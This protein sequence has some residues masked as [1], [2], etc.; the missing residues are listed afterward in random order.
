MDLE[1][2]V[3]SNALLFVS[4]KK[5][6]NTSNP[7]SRRGSMMT[8]V[9]PS[10]K[11]MLVTDAEISKGNSFQSDEGL[12]LMSDNGEGGENQHGGEMSGRMLNVNLYNIKNRW[13]IERFEDM[14]SVKYILF[15]LWIVALV[16]GASMYQ[17]LTNDRHVAWFWFDW[18]VLAVYAI[19]LLMSFIM[20]IVATRRII[21]FF[22]QLYHWL[23][24]IGIAM[25]VLVMM[26]WPGSSAAHMIKCV[27]GMLVLVLSHL[28]Y[29]ERQAALLL[30]QS[31][32][33]NV[34]QW[35]EPDRY[36]K[37]AEYTLTTVVKI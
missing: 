11:S 12:N 33:D 18:V 28:A 35:T 17:V 21:N 37:T 14:Q 16:T 19:H 10:S 1:N 5:M 20:H 25:Y 8:K 36:F 26:V 32:K 34:L 23:D 30:A 22:F 24:L 3:D 29:I 31:L 6:S 15:R 7:A 9:Q 2:T 13:Y 4:M 27:G